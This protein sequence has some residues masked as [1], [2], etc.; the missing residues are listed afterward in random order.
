MMQSTRVGSFVSLHQQ[1]P[2]FEPVASAKVPVAASS[3]RRTSSTHSQQPRLRAQSDHSLRVRR[4]RIVLGVDISRS[5]SLSAT[6]HARQFDP[7]R[8]TTTC[9]K[10]SDSSSHLKHSWLG[11]PCN[12]HTNQESRRLRIHYMMSAVFTCEEMRHVQGSMTFNLIH[13]IS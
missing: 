3:V 4:H 9:Q 12:K 2:S 1:S 5:D 8:N 6:C 7:L 13:F 10:R 11:V